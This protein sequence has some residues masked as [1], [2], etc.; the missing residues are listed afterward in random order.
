MGSLS[1]T[2]SALRSQNT[3]YAEHTT[4]SL[5]YDL[6]DH[7]FLAGDQPNSETDF[8]PP[9]QEMAFSKTCSR[10]NNIVPQGSDIA[11]GTFLHPFL[12]ESWLVVMVVLLLTAATLALVVMA[13]RYLPC[14]SPSNIYK[15]VLPL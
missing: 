14:F 5:Y 1:T 3:V 13:G 6:V 15:L 12:S 4:P 11:W 10:D 8:G 9:S 2:L 7:A